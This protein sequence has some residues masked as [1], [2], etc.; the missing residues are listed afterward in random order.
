MLRTLSGTGRKGGVLRSTRSRRNEIKIA[1]DGFLSDNPSH[2]GSGQT[3]GASLQLVHGDMFDGPTDLIVLP[4]ATEGTVTRTVRT[5]L[6]AFQIPN[7]RRMELGEIDFQQSPRPLQQLASFL[8][9]AASVQGYTSDIEAIERIGRRLGILAAEN[10][11]VLQ[12]SAPL[13]GAG[14]GGLQSHDVVKRLTK[15]FSE[16]APDQTTL[17]I[18]V[19]DQNIYAGLQALFANLAPDEV[20]KDERA[21]RDITAI[22]API[23]VFISY[24]KTSQEHSAWVKACLSG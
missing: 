1:F 20:S 15:G 16:T 17:K 23:R 14:A 8:A 7:P 6:Q 13:L 3:M 10:R 21:G 22:T 12:I 5:R 18:Y 2:R 4:C 24:T 19:L 9:F 11:S